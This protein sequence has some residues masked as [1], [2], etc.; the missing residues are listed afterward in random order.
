MN[1]HVC[2]P[3]SISGYQSITDWNHPDASTYGFAVAG[4]FTW[5]LRGMTCEDVCVC[6][7]ACVYVCVRARACVCVLDYGYLASH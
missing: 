5:R 6:V 4:K 1:M 7:C 3:A 2:M